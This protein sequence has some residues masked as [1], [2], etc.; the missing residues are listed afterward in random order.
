ME[1]YG[2]SPDRKHI[3]FVGKLMESKGV[4]PLLRAMPEIV[5][6]NNSVQLDLIEHR[7]AHGEPAS[8]RDNARGK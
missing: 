7:P 4:L 3:L 2:L 6:G 8:A 5:R 1:K